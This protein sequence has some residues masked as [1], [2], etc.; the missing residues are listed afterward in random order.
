MSELQGVV[1]VIPI[2]FHEDEEIDVAS[3][4]RAVE[5]AVVR[6]FAAICLPAY[7]S[8]F[9][10]LSDDEREQVVGIAIDQ[11]RGRVPVIAQANHG[12]AKI[13][14]NRAQRYERM[15]A[16][17]I[18]VALPRQ[19][20]VTERDLL[21]F[22]GQVAEATSCPILLQDFNPGGP[23]IDV[24]FML[25]LTRRHPN[26]K[27]L[28]LEE[29]ML[30]DKFTRLRDALGDGVNL[31]SGWGGI[32]VLDTFASGG[33]GIMPGLAMADALSR[34]CQHCLD[35]QLNRAT[36]VFGHVLPYLSFAI[37][38]MELF[39]R[40]EKRLL[41]RRNV[42][43]SDRCRGLTRTLSPALSRHLDR[44]MDQMFDVPD[45]L[46]RPSD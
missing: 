26:V 32:Y 25:T 37:Q 2:P 36:R 13:A 6:K 18:S 11:T 21:E 15:G 46:E 1:P 40:C 9:Y 8:E 19:F 7:G 34:V 23:T 33:R 45:L 4:K 10:K 43:T 27:Y 24:D 5:W 44:I 39:L 42:F 35:G 3:L 30:I 41:V 20:A 31:L 17:I 38:N 12:S 28:K 14:A 29:P 16:N 22:C